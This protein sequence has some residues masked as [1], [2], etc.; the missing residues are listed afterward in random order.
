M[1]SPPNST[2]DRRKE[3][4]KI[5]SLALFLL[6]IFAGAANAYLYEDILCNDI[7][8]G[9]WYNT[10]VSYTHYIGDSVAAGDVITSATLELKFKGD[11]PNFDWFAPEIIFYHL[12]NGIGVELGEVDNASYPFAVALNLLADGYLKVQLS[13]RDGSWGELATARLDSSKLYGEARAVSEPATLLLLG[14]GLLG[15]AWYSRKRI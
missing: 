11:L 3:I 9:E 13:V 2:Q 5:I 14:A 4:K 15:L 7:S 8:L 12:D 10:N 1:K 6:V